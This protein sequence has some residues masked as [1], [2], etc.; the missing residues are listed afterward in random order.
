MRIG[1]RKTEKAVRTLHTFCDICK[2]DIAE[3]VKEDDDVCGPQ[4]VNLDARIGE[5]NNWD[6]GD[7]R[8]KY[9]LDVCHQ[10]FL[11]KVKPAIEAL[12]PD[13]AFRETGVD[14]Y[15]QF[16]KVLEEGEVYAPEPPPPPKPARTVFD[17]VQIVPLD[18]LSSVAPSKDAYDLYLLVDEGRSR[19]SIFPKFPSA[20]DPYKNVLLTLVRVE[21]SRIGSV[22]SRD[23]VRGVQTSLLQNLRRLIR[24][25]DRLPIGAWLH[26][27]Q[28]LPVRLDVETHR[29]DPSTIHLV[30]YFL[31]PEFP[32][33]PPKED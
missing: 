19:I 24:D 31:G 11:T 33:S 3:V 10:C 15:T 18:D 4:D 23:L 1:Q 32:T 6:G 7:A 21:G 20:W 27:I 13:L 17:T 12:A 28:V 25:E 2:R 5:N 9:E 14:D 26:D 16:A 8:I 29:D 30:P 22:M